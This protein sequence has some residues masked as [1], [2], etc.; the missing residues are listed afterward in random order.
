LH[1]LTSESALD[2]ARPGVRTR[3]RREPEEA[4]ARSTGPRI[5]AIIVTW[6]RRSAVDHVLRVLAK[7]DYPLA[8]LHVVV[9]D[10]ASTDGTAESLIE[11]W[12]PE[13]MADNPT[14]AAHEPDFRMQYGRGAEGSAPTNAG[15]FASL[16][17]VRNAQNHGGCGGFNT[18]LAFVAEF[19]DSASDPLD[20]AWLIDDDVD[21]PTNALR[22]LSTTA[23]SDAGIGLVGSRTVDFDRRDTTTETTIYFD[24]ERGW[25]GPDPAPRHRMYS[26]HQ[27]WTAST[28][29][30]RGAFPFGGVR[31]VDVVSA[32]SLLARWSAVKRIGFWD[33][34]Y[35]IYCDDADW[36]LRFQA[37]GYRV[38]CDLDAL[39]YHTYWLSKLTP[40]RGYYSQ[41]NLIWV[42]QKNL[43]GLRLK[44]AMARRLGSLLRQSFKAMTHCRLFHAEIIRRTAQDVVLGRG[45]KLDYEGPA[46]I[47]VMRALEDAGALRPGATVMVMCSH[48]E[49]IAWADNLRAMVA[50]D[51]LAGGTPE[52]QPRWVYMVRNSVPDPEG[53]GGGGGTNNAKAVPERIVFE[54]KRDSKWRVQKPLL[55][56]PPAAVV[57]F[58]QNSD[59]PLLHSRCNIHIDRRRPDMAQSERDGLK[60]RAAFILRLFGTGILCALHA[61]RVR[62]ATHAGRY[63]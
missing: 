27:R 44:R 9:I 35:F 37:G 11:S 38:V 14:R 50:H 53:L 43:S 58:E 8:R 59:F 2:E 13:M 24:F 57:I 31:E 55:R 33:H 46:A 23:E 51:L 47:P 49:S 17:V 39:V 60:I 12:R 1:P 45:G 10:N 56:S 41:R 5:A 63:G 7:Q 40:A 29:G 34:R 28:G 62:R 54:P 36:C 6:N 26:E 18:G 25:M 61:L 32:C 52:R 20:Y 21:L 30:T 48:H 15:G 22:Q 3:P 16:A 4:A 42:I 19:L